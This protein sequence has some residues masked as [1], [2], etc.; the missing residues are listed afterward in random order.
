[1][2]EAAERKSGNEISIFQ[3]ASLVCQVIGNS[4]TSSLKSGELKGLPKRKATNIRQGM[5]GD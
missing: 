3:I 5:H 2:K 4:L 1:L